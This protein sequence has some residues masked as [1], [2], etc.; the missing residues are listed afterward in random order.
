[1]PHYVFY[2]VAT[3]KALICSGKNTHTSGVACAYS[4][5]HQSAVEVIYTNG[6]AASSIAAALSSVVL[7]L[8][9]GQDVGNEKICQQVPIEEQVGSARRNMMAQV[10]EMANHKLSRR[11]PSRPRRASS[12]APA[13]AVAQRQL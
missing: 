8:C 4:L 2:Y 10:R 1:M 3:K 9:F 13:E 5:L 6:N 7:S 11:V 12:P